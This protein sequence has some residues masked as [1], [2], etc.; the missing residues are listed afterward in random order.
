LAKSITKSITSPTGNSSTTQLCSNFSTPKTLTIG[1][2][3]VGNIT[4][5][6]STDNTNWTT[7]EG[8]TAASYPIGVA[9][10]GVNY[11]RAKFSV[12]SCS[13]D[14]FSPSVVVYY[15]SCSAR[16]GD[17]G[18][19]NETQVP[20]KS[21]FSVFAYPNPSSTVFNLKVLSSSKDKSIGVQVY[22]M[23]GRLIE[24][25]QIQQANP[26]EV[27]ADYPSGIYNIIVTQD[28]EVK[29]IRVIKK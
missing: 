2:G 6:H 18:I 3:Y 7:I 10:I 29:S 8:A 14:A 22:D 12:A 9:S 19:D 27:G 5:Q 23:I 24:Q 16:M 20:E 28:A 15:K 26:I 21:I 13:P 17:F 4:W 25:R 1:T 11:Y